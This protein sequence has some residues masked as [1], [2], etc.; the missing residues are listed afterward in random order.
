PNRCHF[1]LSIF[2]NRCERFGCDRIHLGN[3]PAGMRLDHLRAVAKINFVAVIVRGVVTRRDHEAGAWFE[4]TN[5]KG[6]LWHGARALEHAR[7]AT[8][9]SRNFRRK[10]GEL[11]REKPRIMRDHNLRCRRNFFAS[12]PIVQKS[13]KSPR[14][15]ADVEKIHRVRADAGELGSLVFARISALRSRNDFAD[16]APAKPASPERKRLVESIV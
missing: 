13:N 4:M 7:V 14:R 9:F 15:A 10:F 2:W 3:D 1:S 8:S 12:V 11:F 5:S 16:R 6:K